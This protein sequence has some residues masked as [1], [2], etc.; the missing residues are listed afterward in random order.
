MTTSDKR[1]HPRVETDK[2]V[3]YVCKADDGSRKKEGSGKAV[4]IS[5]GGILI[6]TH[7]VFEWRDFMLVSIDIEGELITV[8]GRVVYCNAA[9]SGK[10][11][12]GIEF[13]EPS[14]K[15][16]SFVVGLLKSYL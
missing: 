8:K 12:T 16:L 5:Q 14:E 15:I 10:F 9:D 1:R 3:S 6:E 11:R 4:N 7:D 2:D 13:L